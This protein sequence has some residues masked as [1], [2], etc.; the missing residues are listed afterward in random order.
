MQAAVCAGDTGT[1]VHCFRCHML[2]GSPWGVL[3]S[4]TP[5]F[6]TCPRLSVAMRRH[7]TAVAPHEMPATSTCCS[8]FVGVVCSSKSFDGQVD[9]CFGSPCLSPIMLELVLLVLILVL[10]VLCICRLFAFDA[11]PLL[12]LPLALVRAVG[13]PSRAHHHFHLASPR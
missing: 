12:N 8:P 11:P 4:I 1:I 9:I 3:K 2:S 7:C 10:L 13:F 6:L 5:D